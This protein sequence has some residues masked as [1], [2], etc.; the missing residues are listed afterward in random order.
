MANSLAILEIARKEVGVTEF[1]ANSNKVKYNK[2]F[3]G[4]D[5]SGSKFPWCCAFVWW[6]FRAAKASDLFYGGEK[7]AYC[8][9]LLQFYKSKGQVVSGNYK[10]GDLIF[11]NFSGGSSAAHIGIC[12][13]FNGTY[14]TTID[15]NT[16]TDN[17]ANGG[18][19]MRRKRHKKY[20]V[21]AARPAYNGKEDD[22]VLPNL[23]RGSKGKSVKA[24]QAL[25]VACGYNI[26]ID[27]SYGPAT[28]SAVVEY[29]RAQAIAADG[30]CGV[31]TWGKLLGV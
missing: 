13:S 3:Y 17:E 20:I 1:P 16:G 2:A 29:Q 25:L 23:K 6:V 31:Q 4:S 5:V 21:G 12:E 19:V 11:F 30:M 27:G 26:E 28:E 18:A 8:P 10:P 9:T 22:M 14:I 15:G 7:T 24:L